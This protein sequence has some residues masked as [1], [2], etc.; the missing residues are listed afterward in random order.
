MLESGLTKYELRKLIHLKVFG[1]VILENI[2]Q[3]AFQCLYIVYLDGMPSNVAL[4]SMAASFFSVIAALMSWFIGRK[5]SNCVAVQYHIKMSKNEK[6][7]VEEKKKISAKKERK[8]SLKRELCQA[9]CIQTGQMEIGHVN[10]YSHGLDYAIV[11]YVFSSEYM[12]G[13]T[14]DDDDEDNAL[15]EAMR[16]VMCLYN[17]SHKQ[18]AV[19]DV[20]VQHF[21]IANLKVDF[22]ENET[23]QFIQME[24]KDD[25]CSDDDDDD[26]QPRSM[27]YIQLAQIMGNDLNES[28]QNE[29]DLN[30]AVDTLIEGFDRT[31]SVHV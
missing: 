6:L 16:S 19:T 17:T 26:Q 3:I 24:K 12:E 9:L 22:V 28:S 2:P 15:A 21:E 5:K 13:A 4:L 31:R 18:G 11:H 20:F 25:D 14:D 7:S 8:Q 30:P 29:E 27:I 10:Q 23:P 1:S